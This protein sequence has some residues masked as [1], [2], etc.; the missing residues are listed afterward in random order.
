VYSAEE[1][2]FISEDNEVVKAL[3]FVSTHFKKRNIRAF[4]RGY[5]ANIY[6]ERLID[7]KKA[8]V[9]RSKKNRHVIYKDKRINILELAKR[10][11]GKYSLKFR[12]KN[13]V[14]ADCKI[15]IVPIRLLCRPEVEL[16]LA[17]CNGIGKEPLMLVTN[18][19]SEDDRLGVVIT[20]VYL[21]RWRIKE[22]YGFKKQQFDFEDFRVRSLAAIRTLD[23]LVSVAIGYIGIISE[24]AADCIRA[25]SSFKTHL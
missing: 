23:L 5:D 11:K 18:L 19:K 25:Y 2:G 6:Y 3:D 21:L 24:K 20:K 16:N 8:F 10:F 17:I 22:F 9:I 14:A 1:P 7:E 4:D 15:S 13:S 12:K